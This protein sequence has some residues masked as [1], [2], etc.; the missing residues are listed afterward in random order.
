M[1]TLTSN[2]GEEQFAIELREP[3]EYA[4][5]FGFLATIS[6]QGRHWDGEQ[7]FPISMS[8]DGLWLRAADLKELHAY[9]SRWL[10]QPLERLIGDDLSSFEL[11]N[12]PGQRVYIGFGPRSD[13]ISGLNP[14]V[15]IAI[16]AGKLCGEFHFATDQSCL[17]MFAQELSAQLEKFS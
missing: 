12:Q 2:R 14:V 9:I 3:A 6:I 4:H 13:T 16:S 10:H 8:I 5:D 15:T 1:A 11:A 7:S 17:T